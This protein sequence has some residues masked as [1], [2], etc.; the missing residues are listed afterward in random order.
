MSKAGTQLMSEET[1]QVS[2]TNLP[3]MDLMGTASSGYAV[4]S[5]T[6]QA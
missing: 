6:Q 5:I 3:E 1:K 4:L 2:A